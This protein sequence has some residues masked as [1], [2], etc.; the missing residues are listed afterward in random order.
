[1]KV[2]LT[3]AGLEMD[4]ICLTNEQALVIT[5]MPNQLEIIGE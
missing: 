2:L 4:S 1:M 3:S 5:N